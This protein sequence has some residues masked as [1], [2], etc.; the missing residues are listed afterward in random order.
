M[1]S[2]LDLVI[3]LAIVPQIYRDYHREHEWVAP[4]SRLHSLNTGST[5]I[6]VE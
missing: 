2:Y 4:W 3:Y 6:T 5:S 1:S